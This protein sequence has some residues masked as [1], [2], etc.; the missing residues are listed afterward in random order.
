MGIKSAYLKAYNA[1]QWLGWAYLAVILLSGPLRA[2]KI[3]YE[4]VK[5]PLQ[6]FQTL[7]LL[8]ILHAVIGLV[9]S[10]G[11]VTGLQVGTRLL[12]VWFFAAKFE[13]AQSSWGFPV[14]ISAWIVT[15]ILRY[16]Y[17][18]TSSRLLEWP[19]YT[20]FI[21]LYPMG[22]AGELV[23]ISASMADNAIYSVFGAFHLPHR[24]LAGFF[25][26]AYIVGF[27]KLYFHMFRQRRKVLGNKSKAQ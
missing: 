13:Q 5:R 21:V 6:F 10:N 25:I 20:F 23:C 26:V 18:L 17:Y 7:A 16:G 2:P 24:L 19:R 22:L 27:P 4:L 12:N 9:P 3:T 14:M 1:I 15:E 8:E 11:L